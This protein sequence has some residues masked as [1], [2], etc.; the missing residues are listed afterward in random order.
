MIQIQLLAGYYRLAS[1]TPFKSRANVGPAL[2]AGLVALR[3]FR[4]PDKHCKET[5]YL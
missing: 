4:G 1:E 3:F 2:K 5:L